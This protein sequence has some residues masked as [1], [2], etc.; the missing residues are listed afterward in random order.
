MK[1]GTSGFIGAR[2]REGREARGFTQAALAVPLG[3]TPSSVNQYEKNIQSPRPEVMER[4]VTTLRLPMRFFLSTS[5]RDEGVI[6]WRSLASSTKLAQTV[7]ERRLGWVQDISWAL[8]EHL[9]FPPLALPDFDVPKDPLGIT[10]ELI[11]RLANQLRDAWHLGDGP[12]KNVTRIMEERGIIIARDDLYA[13]TLDALSK[14]CSL[15]RGGY[16]LVSS[17]K[18]SAAR[19]RLNLLHELGHLIL[20]RHLDRW[21]LENPKLHKMI[22]SQAFRFAGAFALPAESFAADLYSLSL[23][24]F[25]RLK[26]KWVFSVGMMLK[27]CEN[28]EIGSE[29]TLQKLWRSVSSRGWRLDEPLDDEIPHEHP[30]LLGDSIK[31]LIEKRTLSGEQLLESCALSAKDVEDL[32]GLEAGTLDPS[33]RT[34]VAMIPSQNPT[35]VKREGQQL[36]LLRFPARE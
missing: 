7:A 4:A 17:G 26:S 25:L 35:E 6:Y 29:R 3:V 5:S 2:L 21:H 10:D 1:L 23:D 12:L 9:D 15:E 14:W 28:L 30:G 24:S 22:E 27:R 16:C 19:C 18:E 33:L 36:K 13:A 31:F 34:G 20:H 11:E 8:R 32:A